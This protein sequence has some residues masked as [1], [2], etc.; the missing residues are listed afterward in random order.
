MARLRSNFSRKQFSNQSRLGQQGIN[1]I[2]E[3]VLA[4]KSRWVPGGPGE[5]GIDGY[6]E[7][8][9]PTTAEAVGRVLAVQSKAVTTFDGDTDKEFVYSCN[10]RDIEYWVQSNIP[11][12]LIVSRPATKE[13]YWISVKDYFSDPSKKGST[14]HFSKGRH[15]FS[16]SSFTDLLGA[17]GAPDVAVY[18]APTARKE[19][20]F[21]NLLEVVSVPLYMY[22]AGTAC[23]TLRDIWYKL[24]SHGQHVGGDWIVR[25]K[26]IF[27]FEDLSKPEWAD[28]CDVGSIKRFDT[29]EWADTQDAERQRTFVQLLNRTLRRQVMPDVRYWPDEECYAFE[30]DPGGKAVKVNYRSAQ[31][32]STMTVVS[33]FSWTT[34][35]GITFSWLR[36]LAFFGQ[37]RC[38]GGK[39]YLEVT[40]TYRFTE[41]GVRLDR[42]HSERLSGIKRLEGNRAVLSAVLFWV[43]YLGSDAELV[44]RRKRT[45]VFGPPA[46]F[47]IGM[48]IMDSKWSAKDTSKA[49]RRGDEGKMLLLPYEDIEGVQ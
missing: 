26:S 18:L 1:L 46:S 2:E 17:S 10:T 49:L 42:F 8:F 37:F 4:M 7:L 45:L 6:I 27:G 41:D 12:I 48:G 5:V 32:R 22:F 25:E 33:R 38:I 21:S 28:V 30:A 14:I 39:W 3:I 31:R 23:R 44:R 16:P 19:R 34:K 29:A 35:A 36:H 47:E 24:G 11:V 20:L 40:P 13:S 43:D 9:D 15:R